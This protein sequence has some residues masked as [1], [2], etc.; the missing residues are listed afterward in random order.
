MPR[1]PTAEIPRDLLESLFVE[2][3]LWTK[4]NEG[5]LSYEPIAERDAPSH[6][7]PNATSRIVKHFL[8]TGKHIATTHCVVDH[9]DNELHWDAKDFV[10]HEVRLWR[11]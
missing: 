9:D 4:I 2:F 1:V 6:R 5:K 8:H 3:D 11:Y 7:W 10:M